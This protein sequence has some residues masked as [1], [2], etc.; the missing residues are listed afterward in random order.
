MRK[1][2]IIKPTKPKKVKD[3]SI[4]KEM[5]ELRENM[6]FVAHDPEKYEEYQ[7]E[8]ARLGETLKD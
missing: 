8:I 5:A 2:V 3:N 4:R 1:K 6:R 7:I